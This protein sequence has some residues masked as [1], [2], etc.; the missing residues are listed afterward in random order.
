M[1]KGRDVVVDLGRGGKSKAAATPLKN[2]L[3][4]KISG[5]SVLMAAS[6]SKVDME[7]VDLESTSTAEAVLAAVKG[8]F[9]ISSIGDASIQ[10]SC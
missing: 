8:V 4:E 5:A 6:G 3:A 9:K 2:A 1:T 7:M 10:A